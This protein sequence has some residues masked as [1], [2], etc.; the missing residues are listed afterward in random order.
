MVVGTAS[1]K[2]LA[3]LKNLQ[4]EQNSEIGQIWTFNTAK[5]ILRK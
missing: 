4:S 5:D 1:T 3:L 2:L